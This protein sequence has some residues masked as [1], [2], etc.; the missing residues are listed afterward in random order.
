MHYISR[1]LIV[2]ALFVFA[3]NANAQ[4]PTR[5]GQNTTEKKESAVN[6]KLTE[7]AKAQYP[8]IAVSEDVDWRRDIYR[9]LNLEVEDNATL[10]YPVEP[11][12][13]KVNLFTLLFRLVLSGD[14]TAYKYNLDGN[15]SF[16]EEN[17]MSPIDLL[18]NYRIYYEEKDGELT[19]GKSDIPSAEVLSYYIKE[20]HYYDQRTGTYGK[21]VTAICPVLHRSGE[22]GSEVTKYPMFWLN[23]DEI[24]PLL[25]QQLVMTSSLNNVMSMTLDDYFKKGHYDGEIYKTVNMRNQAI[26]QYCKDSAAVKL[27]QEKIEQELK[28]FRTNLWNTKTVAEIRQDSINAALA[29]ANDTVDAKSEK[30]VKKEKTT[31]RTAQSSVKKTPTVKKEKPSNNSSNNAVRASVRRERR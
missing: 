19:V 20:S 13:E 6:I 18:D 10:Y 27:E 2:L 12:G 15:E 21:R 30:V 11:I 14:I 1:I 8:D 4:P 29:A 26:A 9:S 17:K 7:R 23:Y 24:S 3:L 25:T 5:R 16:T 28:D 22:F 31:S